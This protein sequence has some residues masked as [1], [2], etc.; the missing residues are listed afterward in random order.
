M[1]ACRFYRTFKKYKTEQQHD[2]EQQPAAAQVQAQ[3]M[4][5]LKLEDQKV[6]L[7]RSIFNSFLFD[8]V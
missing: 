1:H 8:V 3:T 5:Y 2:L 4:L 7:E 6:R